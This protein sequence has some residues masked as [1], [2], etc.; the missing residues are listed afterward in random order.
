MIEDAATATA[1]NKTWIFKRP[2]I[3]YLGNLRYLRGG[4]GD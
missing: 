3:K 2:N 1:A 4:G